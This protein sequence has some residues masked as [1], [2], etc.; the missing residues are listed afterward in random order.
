[1]Q[2]IRVPFFCAHEP[3]SRQPQVIVGFGPPRHWTARRARQFA[4]VPTTECGTLHSHIY[5]TFLS[6]DS[7]HAAFCPTPTPN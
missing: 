5:P 1:M 3:S 6:F 4:L 2:V 7:C